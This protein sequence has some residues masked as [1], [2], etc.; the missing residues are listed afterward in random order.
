MRRLFI[1]A[2]LS[3]LTLGCLGGGKKGDERKGRK[4]REAAPEQPA[5]KPGEGEISLHRDPV[6][7]THAK[8]NIAM[9]VEIAVER[10]KIRGGWI[11]FDSQGE[12]VKAPIVGGTAE[13]DGMSLKVE[14]PKGKTMDVDVTINRAGKTLDFQ[15]KRLPGDLQ[16][17]ACSDL[18]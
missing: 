15:G 1:V 6:C 10:T 5:P 4:G 9:R 11:Q 7:F 2:T 17:I 14:S 3:A 12:R 16:N 18:Q 13:K 8:D